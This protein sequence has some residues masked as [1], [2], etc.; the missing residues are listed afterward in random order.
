MH[1]FILWAL[2]CN[3]NWNLLELKWI[4]VTSLGP[5]SSPN[6]AGMYNT[7]VDSPK[8]VTIDFDLFPHTVF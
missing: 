2:S 8:Y 6:I 3:H 1:V 7:S 5:C 4:W